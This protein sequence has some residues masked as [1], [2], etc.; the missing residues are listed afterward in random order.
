[1][2]NFPIEIELTT[3][4]NGF[5]ILDPSNLDKFC[6]THNIT[7]PNLEDFFQWDKSS[8]EKS[9]KSRGPVLAYRVLESGVVIHCYTNRPDTCRV[10]VSGRNIVKKENQTFI[11][12]NMLLEISGGKLAVADLSC[13]RMWWSAGYKFFAHNGV[14]NY[15][16][17][18]LENGMYTV[19]IIE[20]NRGDTR[21]YNFVFTKNADKMKRY[22]EAQRFNEQF[23]EEI[24]EIT[25]L[26]ARYLWDGAKWGTFRLWELRMPIAAWKY[27]DSPEI[28]TGDYY[29]VT[30]ADRQYRKELDQ[31]I[32]RNHIAAL[33][34]RRHNNKFLL[35]EIIQWEDKN[36]ELETMMAEQEKHLWD[37]PSPERGMSFNRKNHTVEW[38]G[39]IITLTE[40]E[41]RHFRITL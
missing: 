13:L 28:V 24:R 3:K 32:E 35:V 4:M 9:L 17:L 38:C 10:I 39:D 41:Y 18:D 27:R 22:A 37:P 29:L 15:H 30:K 20:F 5:A 26:T 19:D 11:H 25:V 16:L 34:V 14:S 2:N 23:D 7:T 1:M 21:G 33:K 6:R 12:K 40:E 36:D 8:A 31:R